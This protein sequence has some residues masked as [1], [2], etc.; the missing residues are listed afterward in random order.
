MSKQNSAGFNNIFENKRREIYWRLKEIGLEEQ[1]CQ[2][3]AKLIVEQVTALKPA[4]QIVSDLKDFSFKWQKEVERII[5][6]RRNRA[7]LAYCIG[8]IEFAGLSYR[9]IPGVLIPRPDTE[10][11]VEA[12][13]DW[14]MDNG[15]ATQ[16]DKKD[17]DKNQYANLHIA[18]IGVGSGII[19]ISLLKRL[20]NCT[21]W[22][23]DISQT[24]ITVALGNARRHNVHDR[25]TLVHGDWKKILPNNFDVIVSNPPYVSS[26]LKKEKTGI[27]SKQ[28]YNKQML[29]NMRNK[30][31]EEEIHYEPEEALF[32]GDDGLDFYR[33]FAATLPKHFKKSDSE[34]NEI[35]KNKLY[36][37]G[38]FEI[39][40]EQKESVLFI[41]KNH[42]WQ[43][44]DIKKD[45]NGLERVLIGSPS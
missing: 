20:P 7:P 11:L 28:T 39:G 26:S 36:G 41:F 19:A 5:N 45:I 8:E 21:V 40:D 22:A 23:C 29:E 31:L 32:A 2:A 15:F 25:L 14:V 10:T 6:M 17:L 38:A 1:E 16:T 44:L 27:V 12:V 33:D 35:C 9:I 37:L 3:E 30:K 43:N 13:I 34:Q 18:E 42:G 4:Q 24:A